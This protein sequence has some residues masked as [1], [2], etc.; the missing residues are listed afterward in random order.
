MPRFHPKAHFFVSLF[1]VAITVG[2]RSI[3]HRSTS[4]KI[5]QNGSTEWAWD[6]GGT[7]SKVVGQDSFAV[8]WLALG[9]PI[10]LNHA[11]ARML[12]AVPGIGPARADAIVR[13]R[14]MHGHFGR[15]SD[16]D[17]VRGFGPKTVISVAPYLHVG[18]LPGVFAGMGSS[19]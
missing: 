11:D 1:L 12:R 14:R 7:G 9:E 5:V 6:F 10:P 3:E 19:G 8:S 17:R 2:L 15:M 16:L 18:K 13:N 4:A